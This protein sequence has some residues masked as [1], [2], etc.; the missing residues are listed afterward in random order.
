MA[1]SIIIIS[2]LSCVGMIISYLFC[3]LIY[4]KDRDHSYLIYVGM[5]LG[6]MVFVWICY[7]ALLIIQILN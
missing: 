1:E 3:Q 2:L 6:A 7:R 5:I 4:D